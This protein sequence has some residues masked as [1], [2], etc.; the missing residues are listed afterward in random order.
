ML[1]MSFFKKK[2]KTLNLKSAYNQDN[3]VHV[4]AFHELKVISKY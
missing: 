3:S 1:K 2:K 4:E